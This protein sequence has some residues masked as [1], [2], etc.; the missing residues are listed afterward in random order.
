VVLWW[1][2]RIRGGRHGDEVAQQTGLCEDAAG[3][4]DAELCCAVRKCEMKWPA[5]VRLLE[6]AKAFRRR[7]T[8]RNL[9][10]R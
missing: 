10:S 7:E 3:V 9:N 5:R 6:G 8:G 1:Y 2:M 4:E